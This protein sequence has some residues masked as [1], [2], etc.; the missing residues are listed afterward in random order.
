MSAHNTTYAIIKTADWTNIDFSEI[1]ETAPSTVRRSIDMSQFVIKYK[2]T[3][4]FIISGLVIPDS[5]LS[6]QDV[7]ILMSTTDWTEAPPP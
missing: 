1:E 6:W 5:V 7:L 4:A 3:P 2:S